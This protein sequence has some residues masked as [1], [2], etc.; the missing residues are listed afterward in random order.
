LV[1][2]S[3]A[4]KQD[5]SFCFSAALVVRIVEAWEFFRHLDQFVRGELAELP[6][7]GRP[8]QLRQ[9]LV[10]SSSKRAY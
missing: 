10:W 6:V 5:D 3:H 7:A 4:R 8:A 1:F 2:D 9:Y